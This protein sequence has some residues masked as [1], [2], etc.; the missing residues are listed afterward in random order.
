MSNVVSPVSQASQV[1]ARSTDHQQQQQPPLGTK[2]SKGFLKFN[3]FRSKTRANRKKSKEQ[4]DVAPVTVTRSVSSTF[5]SVEAGG[6]SPS[7]MTTSTS[8]SRDSEA[9][10]SMPGEFPHPTHQRGASLLSTETGQIMPVRN[11]PMDRKPS[12][13]EFA[14]WVFSTDDSQG[15]SPKTPRSEVPS[16]GVL[17]DHSVSGDEAKQQEKNAKDEEKPSVPEEQWPELQQPVV[18]PNASAS[19]N[20]VVFDESR[21]DSAKSPLHIQQSETMAGSADLDSAF[22]VPTT[23]EG[24]SKAVIADDKDAFAVS[25]KEKVSFAATMSP[26]W[27]AVHLSSSRHSRSASADV[28]ALKNTSGDDSDSNDD[29]DDDDDD[30]GAA[31]Q[32]FRVKFSIRDAAIKDNPDESKA[33]LN[34]VATMLRGAPTIRRRGRRDVRTMYVAATEEK[35]LT[36]AIEAEAEANVKQESEELKKPDLVSGAED[37]AVVKEV[38]EDDPFATNE[39]S[40][41]EGMAETGEEPSVEKSVEEKKE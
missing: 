29:D 15:K 7:T 3:L 2:Q 34:R 30:A 27:S 22:V 28:T 25:P 16:D 10:S 38:Q 14:D 39:Q 24:S 5:E 8:M 26:K 20:A 40:T 31:D 1:S 33:A 37:E 19:G 9:S 32:A 35:S 6:R 18:S 23:S 41:G 13:Q 17:V 21:F 12:G 11:T 4:V 36:D